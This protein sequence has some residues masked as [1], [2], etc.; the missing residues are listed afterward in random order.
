MRI[1]RL[2]LLGSVIAVAAAIVVV[3][4]PA[5][6]TPKSRFPT[7]PLG[8]VSQSVALHYWLG[9]PDA[10]PAGM[11]ELARRLNAVSAREGATAQP[12]PAGPTATVIDLFNADHLGLPQNEES[13]SACR[14]GRSR[15]L[16]GTNDFRGLLDPEG[17]FTGWHFSNDGGLSLTNEGL[18]PPVRV[19][20]VERPSGGDPVVTIDHES[21]ALYMVDLNYD[22]ADP[23]GNTNGIGVY[24]SSAATLAGCPGGSS[25]LC[26]PTRRAAAVGAPP[27]FLDKPWGY[28]GRSGTAGKVVWITYSDFLITGPGP[29][30]FTAQ[31]FA[32]RC[33]AALSACTA[34][35]LISGSEPDIQFSDV[36]IG[37]DGRTYVTWSEI[38]GELEGTAQTF[39]HKLRV[40]QPGST[41]FGPTRIIARERLPVPFGGLLHANDFRIATY[42]KSEVTMVGG[43]PRIFDVWDACSQRPLDTICVEP[44]IKLTYSDDFGRSWS[45]PAVISRGGDNYFPTISSDEDGSL[46]VAWF[47][48][49]FDPTF[50]NRQDVELARVDASTAV[51]GTPH[52]LTDQS[53]E[54]EADPILGG[55]FI[56][57]Y[58]EVFADRG[59]AWTHF[60]ANYRSVTLLGEGRPLPQQDNFLDVRAF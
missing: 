53:N 21:C 30:D 35:I 3:A 16:G 27:H 9:H 24:K 26:W 18:L 38:R 1:T 12:R 10:A 44:V 29:T 47:T 6:G 25:R 36:T 55:S 34:P 60:N 20:A 43:R 32:V 40:A 22:P 59:R 58:I 19:G 17:N 13:I 5:S 39:I 45:A 14:S 8:H 51:A 33:D 28:V 54:S 7:A 57:D 52:R 4:L 31:V 42:Q 11:R 56:G 50:H 41:V 15:V 48:N 37:P 49:R 23:F 2:V 46:A